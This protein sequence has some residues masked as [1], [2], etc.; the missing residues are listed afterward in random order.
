MTIAFTPDL[1]LLPRQAVADMVW[2]DKYRLRTP[3]GDSP[4]QSP[5]DSHARVCAAIYAAD[6]R[7]A[8]FEPLARAAMTSWQWSPGGRIHAAAGAGRRL[9]Y[10]NCF[11][12]DTVP[13]S[14]LGILDANKVV[15]L[16]LQQGGG[17]GTDFS[18]I[19]PAGALVEKTGSVA[20]GPL[21]FMEMWQAT[22]GTIMSGGSR[23]GAMLATLADDHPDLPAFIVA[24]QTAG[25][26]TNFNLSVLVSDALLK[27]VAADAEWELGFHVPPAVAAECLATRER[28]GAPWFVY[29][30]MPAREIWEMITRSSYNAA[31][32]G[33][34]FIER[35]NQRNNL[36]YCEHIHTCNPCGEEP[37]PPNG[38]CDLGCVNLARLVRRPFT[39]AASFDFIRL[40]EL[41]ALGVRFLDNVLDVTIYPLHAQQEE[42]LLDA[43]SQIMAALR[44]S[45]Y[46]ASIDLAVERGSFPRFDRDKFLQGQFIQGLP[47]DIQAGIHANGIRNGVLLT[48]APTGTTSLYYDNVSSGLEPTFSH[49]FFR[50]FLQ[51]DG[52][53]ME[54][55]VFDAGFRSWCHHRGIDPV[56]APITDL[57]D[58]MVTAADLSVLD[59]VRVQATCQAHVDASISKTINCPPDI[60]YDDFKAVYTLAYDLGCKGCTTY[61]PTP[62]RGS[63]LS[64]TA[65]IAPAD[66]PSPV[67]GGDARSTVAGGDLA[68]RPR[69]LEGKTYKLKWPLTDDNVYVTINDIVDSGDGHPGSGDG[70]RRPFELFISSASA[71]HAEVLSA[72]SI[73]LS[74]VMRRTPNPA[75]LVEHLERVRG[76]QGTFIGGKWCS[77]VVAMIAQHA[78]RVHFAGLGLMEPDQAAQAAVVAIAPPTPAAAGQGEICPKCSAAATAAAAE[79][80]RGRHPPVTAPRLPA[81]PRRRGTHRTYREAVRPLSLTA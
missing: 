23:R 34:I 18:T 35:I 15:G 57:P 36:W 38:A 37:L 4:E 1:D 48:I 3:D 53:K 19:R 81:L 42:A 43:T 50:K 33:V 32:P 16:T 59:H 27:A 62:D 77:G 72:L 80:G 2:D 76:A 17:I 14:M 73:T 74:A 22:C 47:E 54:F 7:R 66:K 55:P 40:A 63:V 65:T 25:R 60:T 45:A 49:R 30:R 20:T 79:E 31:E 6:P 12:N 29:R 75:F 56:T 67:A 41:A 61:R 8:E 26:F 39:S 11:A 44:D 46:R 9:T 69:V 71:E 58:Y 21:S 64:A 70:R 78:I 52:S 24:K 13:D 51:P 68:P 10:L 28:N 5:A